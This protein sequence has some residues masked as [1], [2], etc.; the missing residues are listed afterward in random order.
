MENNIISICM[1]PYLLYLL[2]PLNVG[3]FGVLRH[4]YGQAVQDLARVG[5]TYIKKLDFLYLYPVVCAATY[6]TSIIASSFMASGIILYAPKVV[7]S[8]IDIYLLSP[9]LPLLC[10][11]TSSHEFIPHIPSKAINFQHQTASTKQL[12]E[13]QDIIPN[14]DIYQ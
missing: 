11:S 1:L 4:F 9:T 12:L 7:L 14:S 3:C 2:Q 10:G 8:K 5:S 13:Y 6:A